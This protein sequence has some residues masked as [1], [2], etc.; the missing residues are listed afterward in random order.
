MKFLFILSTAL[1]L[2]VVLNPS[3]AAAS[4]GLDK[5]IA[6]LQAQLDALKAESDSSSSSTST[7]AKS[8]APAT[9]ASPNTTVATV[10]MMRGDLETYSQ[11]SGLFSNS[12][13]SLP[14]LPLCPSD[15]SPRRVP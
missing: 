14:L 2:C 7:S 15:P 13:I 9:I 3:P 1:V 5:Q 8:S 12:S 10:S 4:S 11:G 6:D